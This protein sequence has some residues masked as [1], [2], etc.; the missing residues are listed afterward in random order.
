MLPRQN[1]QLNL[2]TQMLYWELSDQLWSSLECVRGFPRD[3]KFVHSQY[4]PLGFLAGIIHNPPSAC[5]LSPSCGMLFKRINY[6]HLTLSLTHYF[7]MLLLLFFS[8]LHI[9]VLWPSL[10]WSQQQQSKQSPIYAIKDFKDRK[11][12][13]VFIRY[14]I[15]SPERMF[16]FSVHFLFQHFPVFLSLTLTTPSIWCQYL[17]CFTSSLIDFPVRCSL[18]FGLTTLLLT[19]HI[20]LFLS[21]PKRCHYPHHTDGLGKEE[22]L[23]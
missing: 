20:V 21:L 11:A 16:L 8:Q 3:L 22:T 23:S 10:N 5:F 19:L 9:E 17:L 15:L 18:P 13:P 1:R 7:Q 12:L 6:C 14:F 4:H 2:Q